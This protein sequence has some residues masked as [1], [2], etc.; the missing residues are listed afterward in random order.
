MKGQWKTMEAV[1]SGIIILIFVA[2]LT[3]T[4]SQ[5]SLEPPSQGHRALQSVHEKGFLRTY[6][7]D[8]DIAS[9]EYEVSETG[10][11]SGYNYTVVICNV[12]S[13]Y[14]SFPQNEYVWATSML[15]S[16]DD[17]YRPSEVILYVFR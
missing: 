10:Y 16:G 12:T 7:A 4:Y 2:G 14:G 9:I 11:L 6:A 3:S 8:L 5:V 13:C 1:M 15:L 17:Q